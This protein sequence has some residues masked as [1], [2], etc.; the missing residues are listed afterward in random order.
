[1]FVPDPIFAAGGTLDDPALANDF[2]TGVALEGLDDPSSGALVGEFAQLEPAGAPVQPTRQPDGL[3]GA[4]RG[5][6]GFEAQNAYYWIDYGQRIVQRLGFDNILNRPFPVVPI[7]PDTVDNAFYSP[8]EQ[9]VYMGVGSNGIH[10]GEDAS[11]ILHEYGHALLDA[12]NGNLL[13][14]GDIGAYHEGFGDIFA[15]LVTLEFRTGDWP[16]FFMWTDQECLRRMDTAKVYPGDRIQEV[17]ADGE[18]YTGAIADVLNA[19][20]VAA[21]IEITDCPGSDTCNAIRD[22]VL[23]TVLASNYWL[24]ANMSMPD[25]A[26]AYVEANE[27][28]YAGADAQ[29]ITDTFAARGLAGGT[30]TMIDADG[31]TTGEVPAVVAEIDIAH[32]YRGDLSVTLGVVDSN[33]DEL[34]TPISVFEPDGADGESD[35]SGVLDVSDT[36]C[37]ALVPPGPDQIWFLFAEDT[38]ADDEGEIVGFSVSA[39]GDTYLAAGLPLPIA[40]AD[41]DGSAVL[42]DGTGVAIAQQGTEEIG[43][44]GDGVPF[45]TA[46]ATHGY[47]GDLSV[48]AGVAD[49]DGTIICS[50][51]VLEPDPADSESGVLEGEIDMS[52]CA[53]LFPPTPDQQWFLQVIDTAAEDTGTIDAFSVTGADGSVFA[54][55]DVPVEVPDDDVDGIALLLDGSGGSSGQAG[56]AGQGSGRRPPSRVGCDH[57]SLRRRPGRD[58]RCPRRRR[59]RSL[60]GELSH[61][62][63][64]QRWRRSGWRGVVDRV[65]SALPAHAD[66]KVVPVRCRHAQRRRRHGR[67][68]LA[69]GPDGAVYTFSGPPTALPDADPNGV[70][71]LLDGSELGFGDIA[72]PVMSLVISH[73]YVGDL[74]VAVG[75]ANAAGDP[76]CSVFVSAA[77][78]DND[79]ID[80]AVDVAVPDCADFY[81]PAPDR[82]WFVAIVD[83]FS[84]D[85]GTIDAFALY[86]PD[87]TAWVHP[88]VPIAIPDEDPDGVGLFFDGSQPP[89][90]GVARTD[91][92]VAVTIAHPFSGD[93]RVLVG[94]ADADGTIVCEMVLPEPDGNVSEPDFVAEVSLPECSG[95]YPPSP[96]TQWFV[97]VA[98]EAFDD[99]GTIERFELT[100]SDGQVFE[101]VGTP[102]EIPDDDTDG[103]ILLIG[104]L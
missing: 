13:T 32:S 90:G 3:W 101:H 80:L 23:T 74:D 75:V 103:V 28:Q 62:R 84:F 22:R 94:V 96:D 45:I 88:S 39:S 14:G 18:I 47:H 85:E 7:D 31:D 12:V 29:L 61:P 48:R 36:D 70:V 57:S 11:G 65:C 6:A 95:F 72:E 49:A 19:L 46:A 87:G 51:P 30:G 54:F 27:A 26:A 52:E 71:L 58:W 89:L 83:N 50:V 98:D 102:R 44:A 69:F 63:R 5:D 68:V 82:Q 24:T 100:G 99:V 25:I 38:V 79:G 8:S 93:L 34:C 64:Q 35:L 59:E 56:G 55:T 76:L 81:P 33:F 1:M 78:I 17:H 2:L 43:S 73:P 42:I 66:R 77:D 67:C 91:P 97:F 21:S 40:D 9:R 10:E 15:A 37:A 4:G 92:I 104:A 60:R 20:L 53:A 86:G 41:P 16:C